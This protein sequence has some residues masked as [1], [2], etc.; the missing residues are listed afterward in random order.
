MLL[1]YA[2]VFLAAFVA[3]VHW[4]EESS[5]VKRFGAEC[6]TYRKQVPG[7]WLR[8]HRGPLR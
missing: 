2:A 6:E 3:F 8:L 4:Y 5:L 1:I 7:W